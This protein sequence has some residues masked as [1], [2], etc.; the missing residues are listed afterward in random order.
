MRARLCVALHETVRRWWYLRRD[1]KEH[2]RAIR[3]RQNLVSEAAPS[4]PSTPHRRQ[5]EDSP[6][7]EI[8]PL[9]PLEILKDMFQC[10][11][12]SVLTDI[13]G[14]GHGELGEYREGRQ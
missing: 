1:R 3:A 10:F 8:P 12:F 2:Y 9:L 6:A 13:E 4:L 5:S 11:C 14:F 7:E